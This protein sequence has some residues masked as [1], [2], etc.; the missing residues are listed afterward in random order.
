MGKYKLS[1]NKCIIR[2]VSSVGVLGFSTKIFMENCLIHSC[3]QYGVVGNIGGEYYINHCTID[4]SF[5][6]VPR[7][8]PTVSLD[9]AV[10]TDENG[11]D[12][13]F[14]LK[15]EVINTI[16]YGSREN[17]IQLINDTKLQQPFDTTFQHNIIKHT[18]Y[19]FNATNFVN[20]NPNFINFQNAEYYLQEGSIGIGNGVI[21]TSEDL[22]NNARKNPPNIGCYERN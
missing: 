21:N 6:N 14:G 3:G 18:S 4:N 8:T 1:L 9:N 10:F 20:R 15:A 11:K 5:V 22:E 12:F 13:F 16:I 2:N 7:S 19:R 17:E